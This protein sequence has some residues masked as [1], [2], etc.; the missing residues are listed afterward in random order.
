MMMSIS[1]LWPVVQHESC[2]MLRSI[3]RMSQHPNFLPFPSSFHIQHPF[4]GFLQDTI[5]SGRMHRSPRLIAV[6]KC[7]CCRSFNKNTSCC[8][9]SSKLKN[10]N[11][12]SFPMVVIPF[13]I[14]LYHPVKLVVKRSL[15]M[16]LSFS[17]FSCHYM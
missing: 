14:D 4:V 8:R 3:F 1:A 5:A 9:I 10:E 2:S 16:M 15:I 13:L 12:R 17:S 11:Y 7:S 6:A